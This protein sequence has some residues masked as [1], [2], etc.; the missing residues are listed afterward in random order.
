MLEKNP[1]KSKKGFYQIADPFLRLWFGAIYPYE[2]FLEF[3]QLDLVE[4]RLTPLI[5]SHIA[6]CYE[7]LCR[8]YVKFTSD[9]FGC[10]RVGRQWGKTFE[11]DVAG[12]DSQEKL[13]LV[14]ECKWSR[15]KVGLS[16]LRA[17]EEKVATNNLPV[18]A[19]CNY[20]L[21][22]KSGFTAEL[23]QLAQNE[24]RVVLVRSIFKEAESDNFKT[25][26]GV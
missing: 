17:L 11:I 8:D 19:T 6:H 20:V 14:G 21:F 12:V 4:K 25:V 7:K 9:A 15:H 10:L 24:R 5:E 26:C 23:E 2:S 13:V 3:D 22:S 16:V 18:S 1:Q